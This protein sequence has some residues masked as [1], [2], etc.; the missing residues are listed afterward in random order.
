[1]DHFETHDMAAETSV[2]PPGAAATSTTE[3]RSAA[4]TTPEPPLQFML[5]SV[6]EC[7]ID[8]RGEKLRGTSPFSVR[9]FGRK[10]DGT[11]ISVRVEGFRHY[12]YAVGPYAQAHEVAMHIQSLNNVNSD[13]IIEVDGGIER[14]DKRDIY[15]HSGARGSAFRLQFLTKRS[16]YDVRRLLDN[17][18]C[19]LQL[20]EHQ[21]V[22][23]PLR[24]MVDTHIVPMGWVR[25]STAERLAINE[26]RCTENYVLSDGGA[27]IESLS[28]DLGHPA[29]DSALANTVTP[30][31]VVWFD[32]ECVS[33]DKSFPQPETGQVIMIG[34][35]SAVGDKI[36]RH[37]L[38]H[39]RS[40]QALENDAPD[41]FVECPTEAAVFLEFAQFVADFDA[42]LVAGYNSGGFDFPFLFKRA[43][44]IDCATDFALR[45]SRTHYLEAKLEST[46]FESSAHGKRDSFTVDMHGRSSYDL[47]EIIRREYRSE[48][49]TYTLNAVSEH[50]L[51]DHKA[52][53]HHSMIP[54]LFN[55]SPEDR[56]RLAQYCL[57]DVLL[58]FQIDRKLHLQMRFIEMSR[59]CGVDFSTLLER[60]Q[61]I[62]IV[63]QLLRACLDEGYILPLGR[64]TTGYEP[65]DYEGGA[66]LE[67]ETG[68]YDTTKP[69]MVADFESLY[70]SL[71][72]AHNFCYTTFV[73]RHRV[74][75][76]PASSIFRT[77][78]GHH[79]LKRDAKQGLLS[80][81]LEALLRQRKIAKG[82]MK[83]AAER[84]DMATK[85]VMNSRQ[86]AL[87]ISANSIYGFTGVSLKS[88]GKL[89][90][91][92]ASES[93]TAEGRKALKASAKY[94]T[95]HYAD[96][97]VVYGD[98]VA[99]DQ[100]LLVRLG[101]ER[102][103]I[104]RAEDLLE[105]VLRDSAPF[106]SP[107]AP[108]WKSWG[109]GQKEAIDFDFAHVETFTDGGWKRVSRLIRHK[110]EFGR[111]MRFVATPVGTVRCTEDHS[112]IRAGPEHSEVLPTDVE[113]GDELLTCDELMRAQ[114]KC[115]GGSGGA[116][117]S[118]NHY[119]VGESLAH[120]LV[121]G[122]EPPLRFFYLTFQCYVLGT[123]RRTIP[124][125][126]FRNSHVDITAFWECMEKLHGSAENLLVWI[127]QIRF[128]EPE[129]FHG[130]WFIG[131]IL[132]GFELFFTKTG[133]LCFPSASPSLG[134]GCTIANAA[135]YVHEEGSRDMYVYDLQTDD[136][137]FSTFGLVVH[138][139]D[140]IFVRRDSITDMKAAWEFLNRFAA[141]ITAALFAHMP[142]MRLAAEKVV[143]PFLSSAKKRYMG[144]IYESLDA[145]GRVFFKGTE[146]VRRGIC[147]LVTKTLRGA[148]DRLLK[149]TDV[150]GSLNV[151]REAVRNLYSGR[152]PLS[153]LIITRSLSREPDE[154]ANKQPHSE[155]VRR[156]R[157]ED[158][159]SAPRVG[160][161]VLHVMVECGSAKV[162]HM[163]ED[164][165]KVIEQ[166][167]PINRT[168]YLENQLRGPVERI[169]VPVV[170]K[171]RVAEL[172]QDD[173]SRKRVVKI[174]T[175]KGK[176]G[177][178][179]KV[180]TRCTLCHEFSDDSVCAKCRKRK[181]DEIDECLNEKRK[182]E[183]DARRAYE[184]VVKSCQ[185]CLG[186]DGEVV[187]MQRDCAQLYDR[188][189]KK[190]RVLKLVKDIEDLVL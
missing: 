61:Q 63:S 37:C 176:I 7:K 156:M 155:L 62:K 1:M 117:D 73:P 115:G 55:R 78:A 180:K 154:Y 59:V 160:D 134:T 4:A 18:R 122:V 138:N 91:F 93:T 10:Q 26:T 64:S 133:D 128:G 181:A 39:L 109:G 68:F 12:F 143:T 130:M 174:S 119:A 145:Q 85:E 20:F 77:G 118:D 100:T 17:D 81:L 179:F 71:M 116:G 51:E 57:K 163:A 165:I 86:L 102:L 80:K 148:C 140:S 50:F 114:I 185:A 15:E 158:E 44:V 147:L 58:P 69:V 9:L 72:I 24:F 70:P 169:L 136:A 189:E 28:G 41:T 84:G 25:I 170:G 2:F 111:R 96:A 66:V 94:V 105:H 36:E 75:D 45:L 3:A 82:D 184:E 49:S 127:N 33:G 27:S 54:V 90:L 14:V 6:T 99:P 42:D 132:L 153:D 137:H 161:R 125:W 48:L 171:E 141:E 144:L 31:R 87:K 178:F 129:L 110:F 112:L 108:T 113:I 35:L 95:D 177:S 106:L 186:I 46:H 56:R 76:F 152:V 74:D 162:F 88:G 65:D 32:I 53:V 126:F 139:T 34:A 167:V 107:P 172:F 30:L 16:F 23:V 121:T 21:G 67:P 182:Q 173:P 131:R 5:T 142:P 83:A 13:T 19:N 52:D 120:Y 92:E 47:L 146:A 157:A 43:E 38:F 159:G 40:I 104:S 190:E 175:G 183:A 29:L 166:S 101:R 79:F 168:Y 187:C 150:E 124:T 97:H 60:G 188:L 164:P 123:R 89:P 149:H 98:S 135:Y 103:I 22:S 151:V 11:S 8:S